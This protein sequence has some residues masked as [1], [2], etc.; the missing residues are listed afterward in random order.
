MS[1][2]PT[3]N[4]C[5]RRSSLTYVKC[6]W[7]WVYCCLLDWIMCGMYA[8]RLYSSARASQSVPVASGLCRHLSQWIVHG[9]RHKVCSITNVAAQILKLFLLTHYHEKLPAKTIRLR[10]DYKLWL[11]APVKT[12]K[13]R[14]R[15]YNRVNRERWRRHLVEIRN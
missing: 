11:T 4:H 6:T 13:K 3:N 10:P 12:L 1:C 9:P 7:R 5:V 8:V 14:Q 2:K 15:A